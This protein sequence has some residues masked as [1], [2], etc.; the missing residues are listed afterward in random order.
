MKKGSIAGNSGSTF[1]GYW[2][3]IGLHVDYVTEVE[4]PQG[5]DVL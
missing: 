5:T 2:T 1:G 3:L 4:I